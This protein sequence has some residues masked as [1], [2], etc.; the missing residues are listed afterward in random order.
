MVFLIPNGQFFRQIN[1]KRKSVNIRQFYE[2]CTKLLSYFRQI[3]A[4][5]NSK[6]VSRNFY[7]VT[8]WY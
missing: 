4:K 7:L 8:G 6:L 3:S 2:F 1:V 5:I